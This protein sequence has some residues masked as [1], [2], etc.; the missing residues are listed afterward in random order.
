[1][2]Q[3][4]IHFQQPYNFEA[5]SE[6]TIEIVE[7]PITVDVVT[8]TVGRK[9][10]VGNISSNNSNGRSSQISETVIDSNNQNNSLKFSTADWTDIGKPIAT[11]IY[12]IFA[13]SE[14][15][16]YASAGTGIYKLVKS[17]NTWSN[18]TADI[19]IQSRLTQ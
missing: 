4:I 5:L 18:V 1:M 13:T 9:R 14:D 8:N 10:L 17:T 11:P 16:L 15:D 7:S 3:Y 19:P 12:N 6:P 2:N